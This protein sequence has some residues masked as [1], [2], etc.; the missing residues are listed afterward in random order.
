MHYFQNNTIKSNKEELLNC[1]DIC[2][3]N[4]KTLKNWSKS[5][6]FEC[7]ELVE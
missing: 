4:E 1:N 3:Q 5:I 6:L 2:V 7:E